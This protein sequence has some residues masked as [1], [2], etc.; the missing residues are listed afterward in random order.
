MHLVFAVYHGIYQMVCVN[1]QLRP[2]STAIFTMQLR[3]SCNFAK[4]SIETYRMFL[5]I[6]GIGPKIHNPLSESLVQLI[7]ERINGEHTILSQSYNA[8][9][10]YFDNIFVQTHALG[11]L[12]HL[13]KSS[14][15]EAS[16]LVL[17]LT[18]CLKLFEKQGDWELIISTYPMSQN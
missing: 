9:L 7:I 6:F 10:F 2:K 3:V 18:I 11:Q 1:L 4:S 5:V 13:S 8:T 14:F 12:V 16:K 17:V 15:S